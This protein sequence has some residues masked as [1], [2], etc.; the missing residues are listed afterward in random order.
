MPSM[1]ALRLHEAHALVRRFIGTRYEAAARAYLMAQVE[2]AA[3]R[4]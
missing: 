3:R 1:T 4:R 2:I